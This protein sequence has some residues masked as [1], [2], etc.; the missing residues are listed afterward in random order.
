VAQ[1]GTV[2]S[3]DEEKTL[4]YQSHVRSAGCGGRA[5]GAII[6][7]DQVFWLGIA[8]ASMIAISSVASR[9]SIGKL[10]IKSR[11]NLKRHHQAG[12]A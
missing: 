4:S 1:T 12:L 9:S 5:A 10:R 8:S 11:T 7:N 6:Q 3:G 2:S